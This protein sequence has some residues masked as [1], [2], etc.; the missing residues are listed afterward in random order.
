M[1]LFSLSLLAF[2]LLLQARVSPLPRTP[3]R[4]LPAG[5]AGTGATVT[6][7]LVAGLFS[8]SPKNT[9]IALQQYADSPLEKLVVLATGDIIP[10]MRDD[11]LKRRRSGESFLERHLHGWLTLMNWTPF[12]QPK[13]TRQRQY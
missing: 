5:A 1:H 4:S 6:D 10:F 3:L 7:L 2:A 8:S 11:L 12:P 9:R 13:Q